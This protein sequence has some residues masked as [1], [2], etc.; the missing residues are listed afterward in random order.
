DRRP[1]D[2]TVER[3]ADV[4]VP[5]LERVC[6]FPADLE[7]PVDAIHRLSNHRVLFH[8]ASTTR[9][10]VS[11]SVR[12]A[13]SILKSLCPRPTAPAKACSAANRYVSIFS[14]LPMSADSAATER[15]GFVPIPPNATR[16]DEIRL[17]SLATI[18]ATDTSAKAYDARSRTFRYRWRPDG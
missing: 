3:L 7:R 10:R 13:S 11:H 2:K 17:R 15:H 12:F 4:V 8:S 14:G 5:M 9:A 6:R 18:T 16:A 1:D